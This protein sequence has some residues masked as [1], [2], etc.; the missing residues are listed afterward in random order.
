MQRFDLNS[1]ID[2]NGVQIR[3]V[4]LREP[5]AKDRKA[6]ARA[7]A[8]IQPADDAAQGR[9]MAVTM[10]ARLCDLPPAAVRSMAI[11]D[12]RRITE[13]AIAALNAGRP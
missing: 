2:R 10:V 11:G 12:F 9:D 13:A 3:T 6:L 1:T 5:K 4:F 7:F 8:G